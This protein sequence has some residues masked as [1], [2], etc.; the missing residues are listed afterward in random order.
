MSFIG[1][2]I[3]LKS[4]GPADVVGHRVYSYIVHKA[5]QYQAYNCMGR[6][7]DDDKAGEMGDAHFPSHVNMCGGLLLGFAGFRLDVRS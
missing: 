7:V 1:R 3:L 4:L 5:T 6:A 2:P